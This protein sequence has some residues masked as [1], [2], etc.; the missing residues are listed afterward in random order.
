MSEVRQPMIRI[1]LCGSPALEGDDLQALVAALV[2]E[3]DGT[4]PS[5]ESFSGAADLV[6]ACSDV[7]E[8]SQPI[9]LVIACQTLPGI[10][11]LQAAAELRDLGLFADGMHF[12]LCA[13]DAT[14][15]ADAARQDVSAYLVEPITQANLRRI[16]T[17]LV[18]AI[19]SAHASSAVLKCREGCRRITFSRIAYVE[20][21]GRDQTIHCRDGAL[22]STRC[23]SRALF[24]RLSG[25]GRF[26]KLGSSYMRTLTNRIVTQV[27]EALQKSIEKYLLETIS[28]Y[29]TGSE[30]FY[31]GLM[32][33]LCAILNNRY[34]VRSN[35][36]SG[37]GRFDIQLQP[38]DQQLPG[39]LF[40]LKASRDQKDDLEQLAQTALDQ[41]QEKQ[42]ET[43]M[44]SAGV[45]TVIRMG[46][47]FRGKEV[48]VRHT[49]IQ[50]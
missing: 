44:R 47:A 38:M 43:E 12:V 10:T 16:L 28:V 14:R 8:D 15:A 3:L 40:E 41:I 46:I 22:L 36:E 39:F 37:L 18:E 17:P 13:A 6:D 20:T 45:N 31:Q 30:A 42:Y 19:H 29:D 49:K 7:D 48:V 27:R 9:D 32:I 5:V 1:A 26:Y 35:R 21:T 23:S 25:D 50:E 2:R 24:A 33:G 34:A 4:E 11:G